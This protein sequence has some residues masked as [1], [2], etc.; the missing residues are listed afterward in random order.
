MEIREWWGT[1]SLKKKGKW[2]DKIGQN[3]RGS[4]G[5]SP[6]HRTNSQ[7]LQKERAVE[8]GVPT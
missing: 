1:H 3:S 4:I 8:Q 7:R 5:P 6:M 2:N